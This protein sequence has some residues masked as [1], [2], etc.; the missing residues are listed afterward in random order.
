MLGRGPNVISASSLRAI[1]IRA[2]HNR[3]TAEIHRRQIR[4]RNL[5]FPSIARQQRHA[6]D[7]D[8]TAEPVKEFDL[9]VVLQYGL[10]SLLNVGTDFS[11]QL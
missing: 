7:G 1:P 3:A 2:L 8:G 11:F 10:I 9:D 4:A 6:I 5:D